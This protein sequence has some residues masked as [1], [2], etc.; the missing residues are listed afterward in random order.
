[1]RQRLF[2]TARQRTLLRR[3]KHDF[4]IIDS[5]FSHLNFLRELLAEP[6]GV[7]ELFVQAVQPRRPG[8]TAEIQ[9]EIRASLVQTQAAR[10]DFAQEQFEACFVMCL[11]ASQSTEDNP[12]RRIEKSALRLRR[13]ELG[14]LIRDRLIHGYQNPWHF[15][16]ELIGHPQCQVNYLRFPTP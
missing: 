6:R 11:C 3:S 7:V 13:G 15:Q 1:M 2:E 5:P 9:G 14:F 4:E 10:I 12:F 16:I 8:V